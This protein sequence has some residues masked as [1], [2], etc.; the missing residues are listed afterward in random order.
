MTA[1]SR[2]DFAPLL[3]APL[4]VALLSLS[5]RAQ[6]PPG[7][8]P[9]A[10]GRVVAASP[11]P[12]ASIRNVVSHSDGRI[13][14][15]DVGRRTVLLLDTL[16][17]PIRTVLDSTG[18]ERN[19]LAPNSFIFPFLADSSL[20]FDP[21]A[22]ALI[23]IEPDGTL[24]RVM[25]PP[26]GGV[27][28]AFGPPG[29]SSGLGIVFISLAPRKP[30]TAGP[31]GVMDVRR[32][33]DSLLVV[34]MD[35]ST[36]ALDTVAKLGTAVTLETRRG[37]SLVGSPQI[38]L[39][40]FYDAAMVMTDGSIAVFRAREYRVEFIAPDR[41][42]SVG[43]RLAYPWRGV[44]DND[45]TKLLEAINGLRR[46]AFDSALAKRAADSA[47]T[48]VGPTVARAAARGRGGPVQQVPAPPPIPPAYVSAD[49]IPDF[50]PPTGPNPMLVDADNNV[51]LKPLSLD[52]AP[53]D[54][55][56]WEI[57]NR[58]GELIDRVRVP[59]NRTI[60]GFAR[61]GYVLLTA[62]DAG[63][64]TLQKVRVR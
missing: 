60:V 8:A 50:L 25:A 1:L 32:I 16:L 36:R 53:D 18:G 43:P 33:H 58:K 27:R 5:A 20:L 7:P 57:I 46:H 64:A 11:V 35:V 21:R 54:D 49:E 55:V 45:R 44:N 39:F 61:G 28:G 13:L 41:T 29:T 22:S 56:V 37:P 6:T 38:E 51:W 24:G 34:R 3:R 30:Y 47:R 4:V 63:V 12:F 10:L 62:R 19:S 9:R 31:V 17:R 59:I 52:S 14:V 42:R 26:V 15:H 23:V 40:P 2:R 48:G